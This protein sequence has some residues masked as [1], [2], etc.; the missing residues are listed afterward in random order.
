MQAC[1]RCRTHKARCIWFEDS[2]IC[3]RCRRSNHTC[4]AP[5]KRVSPPHARSSS[6]GVESRSR[7]LEKKIGS[8]EE[9]LL[10][11]KRDVHG[12]EKPVH[13]SFNAIPTTTGAANSGFNPPT[14]GPLESAHREAVPPLDIRAASSLITL[15]ATSLPTIPQLPIGND[16]CSKTRCYLPPTDQGY[17]LLREYLH[18][19]NSKLPLFS[20]ESLYTL[21]RDCYSGVANNT[22]L[23]WVLVYVTMAIVHRLRAM[24]LFAAPDDTA[25]ADWYLGKSLSKL[26]ELLLQSPSLRLVQASLCMAILLGTSGRVQRAPLF[27]STALHMARDLGYNEVIPEQSAESVSSMEMSYVF[28]VAFFMDAHMSLANQ[29]PSSQRLADISTPVPAEGIVN[30]WDPSDYGSGEN[31]WNLNIFALHSSLGIIE[32]EAVEELFSVKAR[33]RSPLSNA[34]FYESIALKLE[35]WRGKNALSNV[36][37]EEVGKVMYRSDIIHS[38]MLEAAYFRALYQLRATNILNG[39]RAKLDAFSPEALQSI[40]GIGLTPCY[41]DAQR[42]LKLAM[43]SPQGNLSTTW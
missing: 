35:I 41:I 37:A 21:F 17:V 8:L 24:S 15:P 1:E 40:I 33:R 12:L 36:D 11:G 5:L 27:V 39:F 19:F 2:E 7:S 6:N 25:Q 3:V 18:D 28:W 23:S 42:F 13:N 10:N 30:W 9:L 14:Q 43:I 34:R 31:Q 20:P 16:S 26:P 22:P 4:T 29:R 32:A 38:I